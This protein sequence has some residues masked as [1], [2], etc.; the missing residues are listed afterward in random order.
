[1]LFQL[2]IDAFEVYRLVYP[3]NLWYLVLLSQEITKLFFVYL[4][5]FFKLFIH[6]SQLI[7]L[8]NKL[9]ILS[10]HSI[11]IFFPHFFVVYCDIFY[12]FQFF[13]HPMC[14]SFQLFINFLS[15][16][17]FLTSLS[18]P[19]KLR[20]RFLALFNKPFQSFS[21]SFN[22]FIRVRYRWNLALKIF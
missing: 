18:L 6:F 17:M 16:V 15:C 7:A 19:L 5:I 12:H 2:V 11:N 9:G 3:L 21:H 4:N 13:F 22:I 1:M 14:L 8:L 20:T 10:K